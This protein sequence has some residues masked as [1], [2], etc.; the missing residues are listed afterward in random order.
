[1][2]FFFV[3]I[4]VDVLHLPGSINGQIKLMIES[5]FNNDV[6]DRLGFDDQSYSWFVYDNFTKEYYY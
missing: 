5:E 6:R 2:L 3:Q 4:C 1:M